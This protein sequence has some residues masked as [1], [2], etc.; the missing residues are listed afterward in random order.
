[1]DRVGIVKQEEE[2]NEPQQSSQDEKTTAEDNGALEDQVD[3]NAEEDVLVKSE[4]SHV[5][6]PPLPPNP[7][8]AGSSSV[9]VVVQAATPSITSQ[10]KARLP[11]DTI[12]LLE[13][14]IKED[15]R[16]DLGAWMALIAEYRGRSKFDEAREVYERFLKLFPH[17]VSSRI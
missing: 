4:E 1:M 11:H 14:R 13:D 16:G 7:S 9:P 2:E 5:V 12:G 17:A 8:G 3:T 10:P 6:V 15:E